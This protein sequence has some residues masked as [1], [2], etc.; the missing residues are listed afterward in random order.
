MRSMGMLS[1]ERNRSAAHG[2][3]GLVVGERRHLGAVVLSKEP[4][5]TRVP[6]RVES[7]I[8]A[9]NL[10]HGRFP[11]ADED[12][13]ALEH[14]ALLLAAGVGPIRPRPPLLLVF[15]FRAAA[16]TATRDSMGA[17]RRGW[18]GGTKACC[19]RRCIC[20]GKGWRG[21]GR[22]EGN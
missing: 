22:G 6:L 21:C 17:G 20:Y 2:E 14:G 19:C 4:S 9:A 16:V 18:M 13:R 15:M 8:S 5:H 12:G 3:G 11:H 10:P 7:R 1:L